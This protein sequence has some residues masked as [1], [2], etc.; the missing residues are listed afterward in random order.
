ME[1]VAWTAIGLLAATLFGNFWFLGSKIDSINARIDNLA[2]RLDARIDA[3]S[4][5][6]QSHIEHH[7][8]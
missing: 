7:A 3:V 1:E 8:S 5:Q 2:A 6:L 4:A